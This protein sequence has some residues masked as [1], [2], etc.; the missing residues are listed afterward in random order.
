MVNNQVIYNSETQGNILFYPQTTNAIP[1]KQSDEYVGV[2][3][4]SMKGKFVYSYPRALYGDANTSIGYAA[5]KKLVV[6]LHKV[7]Q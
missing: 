5:T 4:Q 6:R 3:G 2:C 1:G 7:P